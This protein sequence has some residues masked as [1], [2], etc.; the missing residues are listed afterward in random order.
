[1][2]LGVYSELIPLLRRAFLDP[3]CTPEHAWRTSRGGQRAAADHADWAGRSAIGVK[4]ITSIPSN[5]RAPLPTINGLYVLMDGRTGRPLAALGASAVTALLR[6]AVCALATSVL[7]R[8]DA[9][10]C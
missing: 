8:P 10:C 9:R 2:Q 3:A 7:S 6:T 5:P 4:V 1:M